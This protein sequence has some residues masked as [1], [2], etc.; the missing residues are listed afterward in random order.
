MSNSG[1][2]MFNKIDCS[3]ENKYIRKED[4]KIIID[5]LDEGSS[6]IQNNKDIFCNKIEVLNGIGVLMYYNDEIVKHFDKLFID[7]EF[8]S[9][10]N[11]ITLI[12]KKE[13]NSF[14][15]IYYKNDTSSKD[16]SGFSNNKYNIGNKVYPTNIGYYNKN[17]YAKFRPIYST[18][19]WE[20]MAQIEKLKDESIKTMPKEMFEAFCEICA[21]E[22]IDKVSDKFYKIKLS[23]IDD[24]IKEY[25]N[26]IFYAT[27][28]T[29]KTLEELKDNCNELI[30]FKEGKM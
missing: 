9:K 14:L 3:V 29:I 20:Y 2:L 6:L 22:I 4:G 7:V 10:F 8:N 19:F 27:D 13:K 28:D 1:E 24:S 16:K 18:L 12:D 30:N 23:C 25:E 26:E 11:T 5:Y 21:F 15:Y 17:E